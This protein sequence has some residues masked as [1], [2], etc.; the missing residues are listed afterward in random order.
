MSNHNL[1][2]GNNGLSNKRDKQL[3][4][5]IVS[6]R[7]RQIDNNHYGF[8]YDMDEDVEGSMEESSQTYEKSKFNN[9]KFDESVTVS[10]RYYYIAAAASGFIT[11]CMDCFGLTDNFITKLG[12]QSNKNKNLQQVVISIARI[13]GYEKQNYFGALNFLKSKA[14]FLQGF[15]NAELSR[16]PNITGLMFSIIG[17]YTGELYNLNERGEFDKS[18]IPRHYVIGRNDAEKIMYGFLYWIFHMAIR[19]ARKKQAQLSDEIPQEIWSLIETFGYLPIFRYVDVS[20]RRKQPQI[21][22]EK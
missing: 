22:K 10:E 11:G 15:I 20:V 9:V 12:E 5:T 13:C 17:Q 2:P 4:T 14:G 19:F 3:L 1:I 6:V 21:A 18:V 8:Y 7:Y 16:T